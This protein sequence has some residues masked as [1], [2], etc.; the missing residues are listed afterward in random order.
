MICK[1]EIIKIYF[2]NGCN[3]NKL[4]KK[5][6]EELPSFPFLIKQNRPGKEELI[7][8]VQQI[9]KKK[10]KRWHFPVWESGIQILESYAIAAIND[11]C[12]TISAAC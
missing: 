8:M 7:I 3:N 12:D 5:K 4:K 11:S 10:I 2:K 9:N 6:K 1:N